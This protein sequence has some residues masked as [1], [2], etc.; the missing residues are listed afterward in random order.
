MSA[1]ARR[2]VTFHAVH[3]K[4][5]TFDH[6]NDFHQRILLLAREVVP[7]SLECVCVAHVKG[8]FKNT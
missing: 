4:R 8:S 6:G 1:D 3:E 2:E 5:E 7:R